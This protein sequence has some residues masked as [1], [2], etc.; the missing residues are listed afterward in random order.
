VTVPEG[1]LSANFTIGSFPVPNSHTSQI[2]ASLNGANVTNGLFLA[3]AMQRL[4]VYP[5]S[6]PGGAPA[7]VVP[8][9]GAGAPLTGWPVNFNSSN[10]SAASLPVQV[11][12]P[13]G[14]WSTVVPLVT[15]PQC[16][17]VQVRLIAYSGISLVSGTY[18]VTP[19]PPSGLNFQSTVQG[20]TPVTATVSLAY[21]ACSAGLQVGLSSSNPGAASVPATVT[22]PGGQTQASFV[23]TTFKVSQQTQVT[24]TAT[25]NDTPVQRVL[26][27]T[28]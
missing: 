24:I 12:V 23:I 21:P 8:V 10:R 11:T 22:V 5:A 15:T 20:G 25:S 17:S 28:P 2:M 16:S 26:T 7:Q 6:G 27:V 13:A 14:E 3:P 18:T 1:A 9:L 4:D 19:P